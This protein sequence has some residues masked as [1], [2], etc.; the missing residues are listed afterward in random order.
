MLQMFYEEL[1]QT[2]DYSPK[3]SNENSTPPNMVEILIN[4]ESRRIH[5][6][7][8]VLPY[9]CTYDNIQSK[10]NEMGLYHIYNL[11]EPICPR[12]VLEFYSSVN[13]ILNEDLSFSIQFWF[14]GIKII[15]RLEM[16]AKLLGI[17]HSGQCPYSIDSSLVS[18]RN[19]RESQG[20]YH[21]NIPFM[22]KRA[23]SEVRSKKRH[24]RYLS[25]YSSW[26]KKDLSL[27][28]QM[29][30]M[31]LQALEYETE[32][33]SERE[34]EREKDKSKHKEKMNE[35]VADGRRDEENISV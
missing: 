31:I 34:Q 7:H 22:D 14:Q 23:I 24:R 17:P 11:D 32:R 19:N 20:S 35:D 10:L 28:H 15:L 25:S 12:F 13:L 27:E 29:I 8:V 3:I 33:D 5:K 30:E 21:S 18:I 6:G 26:V 9:Y 2:V 4:L 1:Q 16:F